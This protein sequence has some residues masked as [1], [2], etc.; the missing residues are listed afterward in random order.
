MTGRNVRLVPYRRKTIHAR[1]TYVHVPATG[2]VTSMSRV[3]RTDMH[4]STIRATRKWRE[5]LHGEN[6]GRDV[7]TCSYTELTTSIL[8]R[9][10]KNPLFVE[11]ARSISGSRA[12]VFV[13]DL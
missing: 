7:H 3:R 4:F 1:R 10:H 11:S 13:C 8:Y 9:S 5:L 12:P 2:T 6:L